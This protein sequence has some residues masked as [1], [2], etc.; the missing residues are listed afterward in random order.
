MDVLVG[1]VQEI[2]VLQSVLSTDD[3]EMIAVI[4]RRRVGKT[5][6]IQSLAEFFNP[7]TSPLR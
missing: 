1:R 3:S 7:N 4:G 6:L 2:K 5:F